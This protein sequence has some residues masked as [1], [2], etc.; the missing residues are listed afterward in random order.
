VASNL[1]PELRH[2]PAPNAPRIF[3]IFSGVQRHRLMD[4]DQVIKVFEPKLTTRA[5]EGSR[6]AARTSFRLHPGDPILKWGAISV[7]RSAERQTCCIVNAISVILKNSM[8]TG[9]ESGSQP[10]ERRHV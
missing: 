4:D 7:L 5:G 9:S 3:E 10:S 6:P 2:S 8:L 1:Y